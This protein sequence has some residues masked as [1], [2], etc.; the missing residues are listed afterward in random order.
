VPVHTAVGSRDNSE[1]YVHT[2]AEMP[3]TELMGYTLAMSR[4][5]RVRVV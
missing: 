4:L 5:D 3:A 2:A 1:F